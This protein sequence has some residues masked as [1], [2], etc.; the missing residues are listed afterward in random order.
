MFEAGLA[1]A[2]GSLGTLR[3]GTV[4]LEVWNAIGG[5]TTALGTGNTSTVRLPVGG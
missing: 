2:T 1:S 5:G 3:G 4:R